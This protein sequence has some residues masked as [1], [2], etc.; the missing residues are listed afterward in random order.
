MKHLLKLEGMP[1]E[2][3]REILDSTSAIKA[4]RGASEAKPRGEDQVAA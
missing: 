4:K 2:S 1:G 3:M